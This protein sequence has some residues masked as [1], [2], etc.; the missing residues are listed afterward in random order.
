MMTHNPWSTFFDAHAPVY[1]N[2]IFTRHTLAEIDFL[3]EELHLLPGSRIL[4]VGCGTGRHAVGLAARGFH[5]TGVD[6]SRGML[7]QARNRAT[8]QGVHVDL[9]QADAT[10][11]VAAKPFDAA[12]CLCEGALCLL[13]PDDDAGRHD[14]TILRNIASSLR[15]GSPFIVTVLSALRAIRN[16]TEADVEQ[17]RFDTTRLVITSEVESAGAGKPVRIRS[18]ERFYVPTELA[19]ILE[20]AGFEVRNIW[21]GTPGQWRRMPLTLDDWEIMAVARRSD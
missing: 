7:A 17:D 11:F 13:G 21:G 5:V 15:S 16:A 18:R 19:A 10:R 20:A 9:V 6:L 4:D 8:E 3:V 12:I 1:D 14:L 2:E